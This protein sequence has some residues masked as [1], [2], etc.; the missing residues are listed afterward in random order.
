MLINNGFK[1]VFNIV[2]MLCDKRAKEGDIPDLTIDE[3]IYFEYVHGMP[4]E[5]FRSTQIY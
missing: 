3:M 2:E 1:I 4:R 5:I